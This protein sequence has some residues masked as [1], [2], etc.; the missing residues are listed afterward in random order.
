M[1][2]GVWQSCS[3]GLPQGEEHVCIF[4][5]G[6]LI[7]TYLEKEN[8]GLLPSWMW[9]VVCPFVGGGGEQLA[10]PLHWSLRAGFT[11]RELKWLSSP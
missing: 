6:T 4:Y 9:D 3:D 1:N 5:L 11:S 2:D 8:T 10:G 7:Y